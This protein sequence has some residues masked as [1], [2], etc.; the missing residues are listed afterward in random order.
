M[1][2]NMGCGE[3][4]PIGT[5]D[6][7]SEPSAAPLPAQPRGFGSASSSHDISKTRTPSSQGMP[8]PSSE[9]RSRS[10]VSRRGRY[11]VEEPDMPISA[12]ALQ[13]LQVSPL[14]RS[15]PLHSSEEHRQ[16]R[17]LASRL[18][19]S[20]RA[21]RRQSPRRTERSRTPEPPLRTRSV[22]S[23]SSQE[24]RDGDLDNLR[25]MRPKSPTK[26][27][28]KLDL[29]A[30]EPEPMPPSAKEQEQVTRQSPPL[31]SPR[32]TKPPPAPS[33]GA[34][35]RKSFEIEQLGSPAAKLHQRAQPTHNS[36]SSALAS[37]YVSASA[38]SSSK[39]REQPISGFAPD[40][41]SYGCNSRGHRL[42]TRYQCTA[43]GC[44]CKVGCQDPDCEVCEVVKTQQTAVRKRSK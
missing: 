44:A 33:A 12:A 14:T 20:R 32:A 23:S 7:S 29:T 37:A 27:Q 41:S 34:R 1:T 3:S 35:F 5:S 38:S 11:S 24:H 19:G 28:R 39:S 15:A 17:P 31:S 6:T 13:R 42:G 8:S 18:L 43:R 4:R 22:S 2:T 9:R 21:E 16:G 25:A 10:T 40:G 30:P 36:P 26:S